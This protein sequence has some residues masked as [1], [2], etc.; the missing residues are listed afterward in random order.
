VV[1]SITLT[2]E[3][4]LNND[5][6]P[7]AG[8]RVLEFTHAVMGPAAGLVLADLGAEVIRVEPAPHGDPTRRLE[9]FGTGYYTFFNRNKKSI[10]VNVKTGAGREVVEKLIVTAD[11]LIENF[12]PGT[13]DRLGL[14]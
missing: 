11:V 2:N 3:A 5:S 12:G 8:I 4:I 9:G 6:L 10:S 7:L 14:G 13:M 1:W